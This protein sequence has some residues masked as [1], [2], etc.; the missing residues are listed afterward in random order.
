MDNFG[1]AFIFLLYV[2]F[3]LLIFIRSG[4]SCNAKSNAHKNCDIACE[5]LDGIVFHDPRNKSDN[6]ILTF[7]CYCGQP[8]GVGTLEFNRTIK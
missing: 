2:V 8:K 6:N 4:M 3:S 1:I 5:P 7:S